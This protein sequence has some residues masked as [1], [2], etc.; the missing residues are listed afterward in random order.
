MMLNNDEHLILTCWLILFVY[1]IHTF[2]LPTDH[3]MDGKELNDP[4][5][6]VPFIKGSPETSVCRC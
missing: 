5:N 3:Q 2:C 6:N 1:D 4:L